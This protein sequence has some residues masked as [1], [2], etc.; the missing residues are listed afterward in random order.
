M[1]ATASMLCQITH[2]FELSSECQGLGRRCRRLAT[3]G[4]KRASIAYHLRHRKGN[5][6]TCNATS[7]C[8][9]RV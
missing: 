4:D 6:T 9:C 1:I 2:N 8:S 3:Q 5:M 7:V